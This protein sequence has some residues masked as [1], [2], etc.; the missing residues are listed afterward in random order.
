VK[1]RYSQAGDS[2][3]SS[4][5]ERFSDFE[6][7]VRDRAPSPFDFDQYHDLEDPIPTRVEKLLAKAR[8]FRDKV[9]NKD[10]CIVQ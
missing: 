4:L 3:Q 1:L 2:E 6:R 10:S 7:S 8:S 5:E 9:E